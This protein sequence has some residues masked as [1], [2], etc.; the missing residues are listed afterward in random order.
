MFKK[1]KKVEGYGLMCIL[2]RYNVNKT[3]M[4]F[5]IYSSLTFSEIRS[6]LSCRDKDEKMDTTLMS[7][8]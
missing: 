1:R 6:S 8:R 4:D 2:A 3:V 5:G 7:T